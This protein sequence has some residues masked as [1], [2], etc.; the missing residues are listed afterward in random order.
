MTLFLVPSCVLAA[1]SAAAPGVPAALLHPLEWRSIGPYRGG[2]VLA[3]SG[4][5]ADPNRF[6]F[7]A[8]N[9]G[10]WETRDAGRTWAPIF[11][12]A[13]VG[14]IGALAVAPSDARIIYVGT[15][16]ADMRSDIAQGAGL[17]RS[18]DAGRSWQPL[19][20]ADSQQIGRI[21]VDPATPDVLLVAA[22]GHPYGANETRG[23]YRSTDAGRTWQ[24]TLYKDADTGAIDLAA[25]PQRLEVVYAALWQTRRP[26]WSVYPPSS[27]P[28]GGLY[29][30]VDGGRTWSE[31]SGHGLPEKPGRIGLAVAPSRPERVFALVD[32]ADGGLYRSDDAG[33]NWT[34]VSSDARIWK[35]GWYFGGVTVDP[36]D[37]EVVYVCNTAVYRSGDGGRNFLP[38]KGAPGGDDYHTLWIAPRDP[39]RRILGA[40]Q[41]AVVT[42]DGGASWSS[43]FNQPTGQFYHVATDKRFPY[44]VYG[45]QQDSGAAGIPSRTDNIDGINLRQF[46][47]IAAG[48]ERDNIVPDPDD[49]QVIFGGR[50]DRLDL[51]TGQTRSVAPTLADPGLYRGTW[52]LPLVFGKRGSHALY[53]GNQR[54]FRTTD[55]GSHWQAISPD[56]TRENP[57]TPANLDAATIADH[58]N[59]GARR[60]V[61]YA[62]GPSPLDARLIWAGTDDGLVWRTR[63]GGAH[64][65]N[66]TPADL[67]AWSKIGV[68]EPSHFDAERAYLAVDRHRLDDPQPYIYRTRDG[69]ASW[70]LIVAGI[71]AGGTLNSVNVVRE[72]PQHRGLLYCG[73]ERG[74][75]VS[76]DDGG[77]W[78]A[79][80]QSLPRTSVRDLVVHGDDLVIATHGR[81]LWI[82]DDVALLRALADDPGG[83]VRLF[84]PA[85]AYRVRP[86]GFLGSPSPKDEPRGANPA[87]G[88]YIDY[89][90]DEA[91]SGPVTL[92]VTDARGAAVRT[93]SSDQPTAPPDL[94]RIDITPDWV[95]T[96]E[97]LA[98]GAGAH[99]FVWDLHYAPKASLAAADPAEKEDGVWAPPGRYWV[100]LAAGGQRYRQP[101]TIAPDPRVPLPPAA[102]QRQFALA[103]DIEGARVEIAAALD[104]A[105]RL[106]S[107]LEE[108]RKGA[109][110]AAATALAAADERLLA[111]SDLAPPPRSPDSLGPAP[112]TVRGLRYLGEAFRNLARAV[113][114]ADA[115][116]SVDAER[117]YARHRALLEQ[118]LADWDRFRYTE[119][120][121]LNAQLRSDG[122]A[123]LTP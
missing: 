109:T 117:G 105:G 119:L 92:T 30:S 81:S 44:W 82:M 77:H 57:A 28:G 88:A 12:A 95:E 115:A 45:A 59:A 21:L 69:G 14:S 61:V 42:V 118:T 72:D 29:R 53:F 87:A 90:L 58:E 89:A 56:L 78:Q 60:G 46:V 48:D 13:P 6:Y 7:G 108:R 1:S 67:T 27:G 66:V 17:Y 98:S 112:S 4:V 83:G 110:A 36:L 106:R 8:V 15:G 2:R 39:Q 80:Q 34:R 100:E 113:D 73:T 9:G 122:A 16:E 3:V 18:D 114:G 107:A 71:A 5:P 75:Y 121:R 32:A 35:R 103:R 51:R 52:T 101:L 20:L 86:T 74:V 19:G 68:V 10:V 85:L 24:R 40:D 76:F 63:D 70:Q 91:T 26:P 123:P 50:V 41:G 79:L 102:Y 65:Q 94:A 99:R 31:L 38:V 54:I 64:W 97:P 62:I 37:A 111:I 11:D 25:G 55:G 49:P 120:P 33:A 43:W 93:F 22:L 84:P 116:P 96:P 23:V 104:Q 47:E